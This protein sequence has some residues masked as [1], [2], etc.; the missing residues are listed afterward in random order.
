[1]GKRKTLSGLYKRAG[2]WHIDKRINGR[3]IHKTTGKTDRKEAEQTLRQLE[4]AMQRRPEL[5]NP[6]HSFGEAA[7]WWVRD[8]T[9]LAALGRDVQDLKGVMHYIGKLPLKQVHQA[10]LE[11]YIESRRKMGISSATVKRTLSTVGRVLATAHQVYREKDGEPW[12]A[13]LP[14][15][16]APEWSETRSRYPLSEDEARCLLQVLLPDMRDMVKVLLHTGLRDAELRTLRWDHE[17]PR[18]ENCAVFL[19]PETVAKNKRAR[20]VFCNALATAVI[21]QHR[22]NGADWVFP[23]KEN[24]CRGRLSSSGWRTARKRAADLY[25]ETFGETASDGFRRVRIHD[26]RHTFGERLRLQGVS[27]DTCGDLLGH[28]GRGITAHYCRAQNAE[29]LE[30]VR[31]LEAYEVPQK[32]RKGTIVPLARRPL[33]GKIMF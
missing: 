12:L 30:A 15:L 7:L 21:D 16:I 10:T 14:K 31:R 8:N 33:S 9:H 5:L 24:R 4:K 11:P 28:V 3:R 6:S 26:L 32:S 20:L 17:Q 27:L 29:L 18:Q 25:E 19:I 13:S 22:N 23:G 1:M 2:I